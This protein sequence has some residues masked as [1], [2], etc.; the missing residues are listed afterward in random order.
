M[1]IRQIENINDTTYTHLVNRVGGVFNTPEWLSVYTYHLQVMGVFQEHKLVAVFNQWVTKKGPVKFYR[2]PPL[3]PNNAFVS[4]TQA[5][6]PSNIL[7]E[8]KEVIEAVA[9]YYNSLS[10]AYVKVVFP[11]DVQDMQPFAWLNF[12]L[13]PAY[14]YQM[15]LA[16]TPPEL[17]ARMSVGHRNALKK[18]TKDGVTCSQVSD[19]AVVKDLVTKSF[20]RKNK[21]TNV[22]LIDNILFNFATANNSYA[23]VA[24]MQEQPIAAAFCVYDREH[25]YYLLGGYDAKLRHNG[26]GIMCLYNCMLRAAELDKSV[27]DFEGSMLPEVEKY[28]RGFGAKLTPY[29]S[30]QKSNALVSAIMRIRSKGK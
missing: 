22:K 23:F 15:Q 24:Y 4:I 9:N 7:S 16:H 29:F 20:D 5:T 2:T 25:V 3:T 19:L 12:K 13:A 8:N 17:E 14:T 21:S 10:S 26:A 6:N 1:E 11:P 18:A 28:F 27:F 30:A